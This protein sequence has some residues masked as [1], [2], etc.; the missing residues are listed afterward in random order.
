MKEQ[1]E[2]IRQQALAE[3]SEA[4]TPAQLEDLRVRILGKKGEL[5]AVLKQMGKFSD[6]E[7]AD[8][9][10]VGNH[11][12]AVGYGYDTRD[13]WAN[14]SSVKAEILKTSEMIKSGNISAG[15]IIL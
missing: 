13:K 3:L 11:I 4:N 5:T 1:L 15:S 2:L 14:P 8:H 9:L 12:Y 7:N 10:S 6:P